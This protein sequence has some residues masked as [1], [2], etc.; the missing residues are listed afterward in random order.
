[1]RIDPFN[2]DVSSL[3]IMARC[4]HIYDTWRG[5]THWELTPGE[6]YHVT[7]TRMSS[8]YTYVTLEGRDK[9]YN[10]VCFEFLIDGKEH[11]IYSDERCWSDALIRLH[12]ALEEKYRQ[13]TETIPENEQ[14]HQV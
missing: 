9:T 13:E 12:K 2:K 11:D 6:K 5:I 4:K 10:S 1:M 8:D 3:G 7:H 14:E